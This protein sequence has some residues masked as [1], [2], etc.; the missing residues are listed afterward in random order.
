M[1]EVLPP[2]YKK[3]LYSDNF[4]TALAIVSIVGYSIW[5]ILRLWAP[6]HLFYDAGKP[7]YGNEPYNKWAFFHANYS[8]IYSLWGSR[9]LFLHKVPYVNNKIEYPV[10]MGIYMWF[11]SFAS[12]VSLYFLFSCLGIVV[13]LA[14]SIY[15]LRK[16]LPNTYYLF[17]ISPL[18]FGYEFLNWDV[19]GILFLILGVY[20]YKNDK[21]TASAIALA[22][23]TSVKFYPIILLYY[24]C[25]SA[26]GKK[27]T[28]TLKRLLLSFSI[29]WLIINIYFMISNFSN[30]SY[31]FT[32]NFVREGTS[33][34]LDMFYVPSPSFAV[35]DAVAILLQLAALYLT[36][37]LTY[38][39]RITPIVASTMFF[40]IFL[41]TNKIYS[42]QYMLWLLILVLISEF[43]TFVCW[44]LAAGG[45]IDYWTMW[46]F[47][48]FATSY[49][50]PQLDAPATYV[51]NWYQNTIEPVGIDARYIAIILAVFFGVYQIKKQLND[52]AKI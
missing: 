9:G 11:M 14:I 18:L 42:P 13:A 28:D 22:I 50:K 8:D 39:S 46:G 23:G 40:A 12:N 51:F 24:F 3:V 37:R 45:L 41:L 17:A 34:F 4:K 35:L 16:I 27:E 33:G 44:I 21:I 31:F 48:Y 6:Q 25:I 36:T 52:T 32:F 30:W 5:G 29:T 1:L 19:L 43:P 38:K 15:Y 10:L 26:F 7:I 49:P 2:N 47:L 20:F